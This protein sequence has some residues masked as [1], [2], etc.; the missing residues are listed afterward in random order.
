[1][2]KRFLPFVA[3][4]SGTRINDN[5]G[6][7]DSDIYLSALSSPNIFCL[8]LTS[9]TG[10]TGS[11]GPTGSSNTGPTGPTGAENIG[12]IGF[13][14]STGATGPTGPI[15]SSVIG[16]TGATGIGPTGSSGV[17]TLSTISLASPTGT[18]VFSNIPQTYRHLKL[19]VGARSAAV[20]VTDNLNIQ[21]NWTVLIQ[22][23]T[24]ITF[25]NTDA[26]VFGQAPVPS[27]QTAVVGL[28]AGANSSANYFGITTIDI[29]YY[30]TP[31]TANSAYATGRALLSQSVVNSGTAG[32]NF[33]RITT[34]TPAGT[35]F[36]GVGD[37][38]ISS[39]TFSLSSGSTF[40]AG[41]YFVL[42]AY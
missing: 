10:A 38:A 28:A 2:P 31:P 39:I 24:S 7:P 3:Q 34:C 16:M 40:N 8:L 36:E 1:M 11:T 27:L 22:R 13:S 20:A 37:W 33:S 25:N 18:V 14:G 26:P 19:Q 32:N 41:S 15:G 30:A 17:M 4:R 29:P 9:G 6:R 42:Q 23:Y 35:D 21:F 12:P 5:N